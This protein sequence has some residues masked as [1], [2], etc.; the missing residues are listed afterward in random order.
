MITVTITGDKGGAGK[1]TMSVILSEYLAFQGTRVKMVDSDPTRSLQT[2][3]SK[4]EDMQYYPSQT[5]SEIEVIDC[6][7]SSGAGASF[8]QRAD[9]IILPLKLHTADLEVGL[10]WFM[11]LKPSIQEKVLFVPNELYR[12]GE[13]GECRE[14]IA[15]V[16]NDEGHG[17]LVHGL[18]FRPANFGKLLNGRDG[19]I[20][21]CGRDQFD[22]KAR[23]EAIEFAESASDKLGVAYG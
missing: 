5:G 9:L 21:A 2:W 13:Q 20:F 16:I 11:N 19:N 18:S 22:A 8:I 1:T 23:Y 10:S 17:T 15:Q 6:A 3:I 14:I 12:T 7:G 4:C